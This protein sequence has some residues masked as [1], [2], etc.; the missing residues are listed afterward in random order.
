MNAICY[1][2]LTF[3]IGFGA[4]CAEAGDPR[5]EEVVVAPLPEEERVKEVVAEII[6]PT[7]YM[8]TPEVK[9]IL[10]QYQFS[11]VAWS[12]RIADIDKDLRYLE[13]KR[14][15]AQVS[16]NSDAMSVKHTLREFVASQGIPYSEL[17]GWKISDDGLRAVLKGGK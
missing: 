7:E 10:Q 9:A 13:T 2:L 17:G 12:K 15:T 5:L 8:L 11:F 3:F 1:F 14:K 6:P 16:Q 4:G